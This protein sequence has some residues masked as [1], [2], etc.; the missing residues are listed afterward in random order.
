MPGNAGHT[1]IISLLLAAGVK[2]NHRDKQK[3]TALLRAVQADKPAA[4]AQLLGAEQSVQ[5]NV[6]NVYRE[7]PL[8]AAC[9]NGNLDLART[10][11]EAGARADA[12]N[13]EEETP[14]DL[15]PR[16]QAPMRDTLEAL[17]AELADA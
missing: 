16:A 1:D 5:V 14:F 8:H 13:D 11:L 2:L 15:I 3:S 6:K 12:T 7:T 17:V 10:L 9:A 4:V